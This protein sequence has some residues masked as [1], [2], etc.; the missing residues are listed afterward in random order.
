MTERPLLI[1]IHLGYDD[2]WREEGEL[3]AP[4]T[5]FFDP[6]ENKRHLEAL[7]TLKT[8]QV[9]EIL[10]LKLTLSQ[11]HSAYLS[12][13]DRTYRGY[14]GLT[15]TTLYWYSDHLPEFCQQTQAS[16]SDINLIRPIEY[17]LI[18][19]EEDHSHF[20][21]PSEEFVPGIRHNFINW[22]QLV[23]LSGYD[24]DL[25]TYQ[26]LAEERKQDLGE[27]YMHWASKLKQFR[28]KE[29]WDLAAPD[30]N[31]DYYGLYP[32]RVKVIEDLEN[33]VELFMMDFPIFRAIAEFPSPPKTLEQRVLVA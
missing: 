8:H 6:D 1:K 29:Y 10:D 12:E 15:T 24:G 3:L 13:R 14:P 17:A 33:H 2:P 19:K 27:L 28:A 18:V 21:I 16:L 9:R 11:A 25:H 22:L 30:Y 5:A 23:S 32:K 20:F 26:G 31:P 4:A 7:K